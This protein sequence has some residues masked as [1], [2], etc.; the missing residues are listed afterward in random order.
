[1]DG[2]CACVWFLDGRTSIDRPTRHTHSVNLSRVYYY[3][4][5][6]SYTHV[7]SYV[8]DIIYVAINYLTMDDIPYLRIRVIYVLQSIARASEHCVFRSSPRN[9][10]KQ[11]ILTMLLDYMILFTSDYLVTLV[12]GLC[13]CVKLF[14]SR[15]CNYA[16]FKCTCN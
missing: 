4:H 13:V 12:K 5:T 14:Q 2:V 3:L 15:S 16:M 11:C 6:N 8:V 9:V 7:A 10:S 1:M